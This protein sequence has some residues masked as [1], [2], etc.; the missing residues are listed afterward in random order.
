MQKFDTI[1]VGAG[2]GGLSCA[3]TLARL[4]QNVLVLERN[5]QV[6]PKVC[7]GGV[8]KVSFPGEVPARI[9]ERSFNRHCILS[10]WQRVT[11]TSASPIIYTV[12]REKLGQWMME[13]ALEAG[14]TVKT[15]ALVVKITPESVVTK[16]GR[17]GY[18]YLVGADGSSSIVRRYL[19]IITSRTG[20]GINYQVPGNFDNL[21]WYLNTSLFHSGY[22]WIFPYRGYASIGAYACNAIY[23]PRLLLQK[24]HQWSQKYGIDLNQTKH[25]AALINYD[26]RGWRF[27]N[28][29]L[30]GDA[31]GLASGL[32]GEGIYPAMLS[33]KTVANVIMDE[34]YDCSALEKLIR[35]QHIHTKMLGLTSQNKF[36]CKLLLEFLLLW[37]RPGIIPY[38]ALELGA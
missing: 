36:F 33:G 17:F 18:R 14:A 38:S 8:P 32:T 21:E 23:S 13:Q 19:R 5:S 24:L 10:G 30:V 20:T 26:Y 15:N 29:F 7:A 9:I 11:I 12:S 16:E 37:L 34:G 2:P 25:R 22:A 6:G 27:G 4:G 35:K 1:I 31:A 3:T 28:T